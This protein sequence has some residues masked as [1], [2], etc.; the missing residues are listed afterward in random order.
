MVVL[1]VS[2]PH[3]VES[4]SHQCES[5]RASMVRGFREQSIYEIS[6]L[7]NVNTHEPRPPRLC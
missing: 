1:R 6:K 4:P 5:W 2:T 3:C 7:V